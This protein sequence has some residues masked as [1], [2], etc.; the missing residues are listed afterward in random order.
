LFHLAQHALNTAVSPT[1]VFVRHI[2]GTSRT[3]IVITSS[4]Q[5]LI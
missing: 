1:A 2:L 4:S 5:I 3:P